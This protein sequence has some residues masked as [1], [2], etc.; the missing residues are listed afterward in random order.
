MP[1]NLD[2]ETF[3]ATQLDNNSEANQQSGAVNGGTE[4]ASEA[5]RNIFFFFSSHIPGSLT[6]QII[7]THPRVATGGLH[8]GDGGED[9][10][11]SGQAGG[12]LAAIG[13]SQSGGD[14][15]RIGAVG[16]PEV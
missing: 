2:S 6:G 16:E 1:D 7:G 10:V 11:G 12:A 5:Q 14:L 15:A 3:C 4:Q 9:G 13:D 8:R